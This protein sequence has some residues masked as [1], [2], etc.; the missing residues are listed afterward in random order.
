VDSHVRAALVLL[1]GRLVKHLGRA[2][3]VVGLLYQRVDLLAAL[4]RGLDGVVKNHLG[5]LQLVHDAR[6]LVR[7]RR[8]LEL[9]EQAGVRWESSVHAP[10][11]V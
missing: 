1:F 8:V 3:Q 5:L 4:E 10:I 6:E 7:L 11:L 2:R 9:R